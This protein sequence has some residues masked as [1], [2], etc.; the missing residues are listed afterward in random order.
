MNGPVTT[1]WAVGNTAPAAGVCRIAMSSAGPAAVGSSTGCK[2]T[3]SP[4]DRVLDLA[5]NVEEWD[6]SGCRFPDAGAMPDT[7]AEI[8]CGRRGGSYAH[9]VDDSKCITGTS[10]PIDTRTARL[11]FRCC[12]SPL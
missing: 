5:G 1:T 12:K 3:V 6:N 7:F 11:G 4:Y 2:G 10:A 8:Q 9:T